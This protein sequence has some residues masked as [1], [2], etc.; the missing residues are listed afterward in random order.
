MPENEKQVWFDM[1]SQQQKDQEQKG[2]PVFRKNNTK[3]LWSTARILFC[4]GAIP[5]TL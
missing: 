2:L 3:H 1:A 4:G 5:Q